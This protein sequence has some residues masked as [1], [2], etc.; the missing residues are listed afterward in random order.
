MADDVPV[1][2]MTDEGEGE[3]A[4]TKAEVVKECITAIVAMIEIWMSD[5]W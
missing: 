2:D 5:L 4:E 1:R 3:M